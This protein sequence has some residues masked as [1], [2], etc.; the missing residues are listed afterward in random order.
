MFNIISSLMQGFE[1]HVQRDHNMWAYVYYSHYL[2][3]IDTSNHTAIQ[4]YVSSSV[5]M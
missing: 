3:S 5:S 2:D 1:N 4:K